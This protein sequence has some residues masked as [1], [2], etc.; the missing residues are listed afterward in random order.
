MTDFVRNSNFKNWQFLNIEDYFLGSI[1]S[2]DALLMQNRFLVG[3]GPS[4]KTWPELILKTIFYKG[5]E[6][7][8]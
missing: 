4:L 1:N 6:E 8:F 5:N 7:N 2:I 3:L